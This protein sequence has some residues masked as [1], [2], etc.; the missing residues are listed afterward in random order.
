FGARD[1]DP[2]TGRWTAKDPMAFKAY[3]SNL[4]GYVL[5]DPINLVDLEGESPVVLGVALGVVI[6]VAIYAAVDTI[7]K[8]GEEAIKE[9]DEAMQEIGGPNSA[10]ACK[11][12]T[13]AQEKFA[14]AAKGGAAF[15][16]LGAVASPTPR[17]TSPIR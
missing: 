6:S 1:Y 12:V 8:L 16:Q 15:G 3:S 5:N 13:E 14:G 2:Q 4:Y 11:S 17:T 7:K 9:R 10:A